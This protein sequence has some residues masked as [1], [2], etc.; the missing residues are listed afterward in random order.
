M[1]MGRKIT[2]EERWRDS[3]GGWQGEAGHGAGEVR[4]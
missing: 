3:K 2:E 4:G 1:T